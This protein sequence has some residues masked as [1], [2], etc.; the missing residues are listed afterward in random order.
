MPVPKVDSAMV[1]LEK[2]SEETY[3]DKFY[4]FM[5]P[6][7]LAKRKKLLN[8]LLPSINKSEL[9][10]LLKQLGYDDNVRS[11]QLDYHDWM[12]LYKAL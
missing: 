1:L 9:I 2:K 6:F 10:K 7:F 8:N 3:D 12:K 5:R 4:K 11:E